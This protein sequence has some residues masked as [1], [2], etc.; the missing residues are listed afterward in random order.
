MNVNQG[1]FGQ[2]TN[3][4]PQL[5]SK[6]ITIHVRITI[7]ASSRDVS[8]HVTS[9]DTAFCVQKTDHRP[10]PRTSSCSAPSTNLDKHDHIT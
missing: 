6:V 9:P 8:G 5:D 1:S 3:R 10:R 2:G 7:P 4:W